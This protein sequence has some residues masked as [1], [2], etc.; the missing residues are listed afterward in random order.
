MGDGR[1]GDAD[2]DGPWLGTVPGQGPDGAPV[3][4][5]DDAGGHIFLEPVP[6]ELFAAAFG[7]L[8]KRASRVSGTTRLAP[9]ESIA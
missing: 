5:E 9:V 4:D 8:A 2:F 3:F 6:R 1:Q 7:K